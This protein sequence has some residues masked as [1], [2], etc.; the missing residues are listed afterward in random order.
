L[1]YHLSHLEVNQMK[2]GDFIRINYVGRLKETREIFDLTK[3]DVAK[4]EKV[5]DPKLKYAPVPVLVGERFVL[6]G[7]DD[8]L[9]NMNLGDKKKVSVKPLDAFGERDPKMIKVIP[10]SAFRQQK[11]E[12]VPGMIINMSGFR[13]RI[14]SCESGRVRV[15]FNNPL[16][17]KE[18]EYDIEIIEKI[19]EPEAKIKAIFEFMGL[20]GITVKFGDNEVEIEI[21][22]PLPPELKSHVTELVIKYVSTEGKKIE[23]V[24]FSEVFQKAEEKKE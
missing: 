5:Y 11:M 6:K 13:G 14:Q 19:S 3:E 7:L 22:R 16:A 24:K 4:E 10:K 2:K 15:D 8:E 23:K 20:E 9:L 21:P 1:K 18:L 17:G 12:P